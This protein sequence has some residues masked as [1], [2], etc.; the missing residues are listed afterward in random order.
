MKNYNSHIPKKTLRYSLTEIIDKLD[1]DSISYINYLYML[2]TVLNY[3]SFKVN[4]HALIN[5]YN[6]FLKKKW[7]TLDLTNNW[8][9]LSLCLLWSHSFIDFVER[10][11]E[12]L[13]HSLLLLDPIPNKHTCHV[14]ICLSLLYDL[15]IILLA[16]KN[17]WVNY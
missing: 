3:F 2:I 9:Y 4:C 17:F 11:L 1:I 12:L 5:N 15:K 10:L 14:S 6:Y 16:S 13:D 8:W 7:W